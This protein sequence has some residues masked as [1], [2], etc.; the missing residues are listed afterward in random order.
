[1]KSRSIPGILFALFII[2]IGSGCK[3][4]FEKIRISNDPKFILEKAYDYY[5][6]EDYLKA[7]TL[8]ELVLNQFRGTKEAEKMFFTYA[9]THYHLRQYQLASHYFGSF[10]T[11]FAYSEYRE[12]AA[13]ME[14]YS[15]YQLSPTFRLDQVATVDA[16]QNFQEFV[17]NYPNSSRVEE[18]NKLIDELREKL[19]E[20]AFANGEL[21]YKL[22]DYQAAIQSFEN[23][24]IE[25]PDSDKGEEI[26][27]LIVKSAFQ[28]AENSI[29]ERKIERYEMTLK[30]H[31]DF[32]ARYPESKYLREIEQIQQETV[33][34][35][36]LLAHDGH[37]N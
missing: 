29:Y 33:N 31:R 12:E 13:F 24:L 36:N 8:F 1:M 11:T 25:F 14:A 18:C 32:I 15:S 21:Y 5:E 7:Q 2:V 20:K 19:E 4:E 26:Q 34:Q 37:Q 30:K 27:Y 35:L 3:S 6:K 16:I 17:D 22:E 9:Y 28:Y 23:M 10:A